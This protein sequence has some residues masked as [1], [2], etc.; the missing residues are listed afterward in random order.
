MGICRPFAPGWSFD[1]PQLRLSRKSGPGGFW[2][3]KQG[4]SCIIAAFVL[5]NDFEVR[6]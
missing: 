1:E 6:L 5:D 3:E 4:K 2:V